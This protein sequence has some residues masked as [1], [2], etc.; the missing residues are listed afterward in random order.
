MTPSDGKKSSGNK[1]SLTR[2]KHYLKE[3]LW[4]QRVQELSPWQRYGV[5]FLRI[6]TLSIQH[7]FLNKCMLRAS[8]LTFY[9][10]L[11]IVPMV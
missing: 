2:A 7:F 8:A 1:S 11:S 4:N 9:T 6:L 5:N 3:D 10:M